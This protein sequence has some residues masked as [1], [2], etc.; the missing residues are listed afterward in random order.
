VTEDDQTQRST[1]G[2]RIGPF[3]IGLV[4]FVGCS[5]FTLFWGFIT[6]TPIIEQRCLKDWA[7]VPAVVEES[8][9][10]E[11]RSGNSG[12]A[13]RYRYTYEGKEYHS[14]RYQLFPI[15]SVDGDTLVNLYSVGRTITV[16][17]DPAH[18][19]S[20]FVYAQPLFL[21]ALLPALIGLL[22]GCQSA[23]MMWQ[24]ITSP[25]VLTASVNSPDSHGIWFYF[26]DSAEQAREARYFK[27]QEN[28]F[29][30]RIRASF[31]SL[32]FVCTGLG[33]F[34]ALLVIDHKLIPPF[35]MWF[36]YAFGTLALLAGG[37]GMWLY[38]T[39]KYVVHLKNGL[40]KETFT[41]Y[42]TEEEFRAAQSLK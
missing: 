9:A 32:I 36:G 26:F 29:L 34:I 31:A 39:A 35:F 2:D 15:N 37:H 10:I 27:P 12:F 22:V 30:T 13:I 3:F 1:F 23:Y 16:H 38:L 5:L 21:W 8:R 7:Q 19:R 14:R 4:F 18:P 25:W 20:A 42:N 41:C 24:S 11:R 40:G 6:I 17:V 33:I 28:S